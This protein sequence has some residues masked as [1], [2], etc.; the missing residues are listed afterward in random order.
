MKLFF[1]TGNKGKFESINNVLKK[2]GIEL[3]QKSLDIKEIRSDNIEEIATHKAIEAGKI[4]NKP[5]IVEDSGFFIPSLNGFPGPYVRFV[6]N[7]MGIE[8]LLKVIEGLDKKCY[9]RSVIVFWHPEKE[10]KMFKL[11]E[12]G[13]LSDQQ[14]GNDKSESWSELWKVYVPKGCSKPIAA[15]TD[16]EYSRSREEWYDNFREFAKWFVKSYKFDNATG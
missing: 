7:T 15:L 9:F 2:Y 12:H 8:K 16:G 11:D 5:L 14:T 10:I 4:L 13:T 6:L 3:I 1:V